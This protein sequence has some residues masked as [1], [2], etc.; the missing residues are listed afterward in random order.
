[1]S[2]DNENEYVDERW[3]RDDNKVRCD[4]LNR[5]SRVTELQHEKYNL[6]VKDSSRNSRELRRKQGAFTIVRHSSTMS[7]GSVKRTG[8]NAEVD[9]YL[10]LWQ[11][12]VWLSVTPLSISKSL[13]NIVYIIV[14]ESQ[15]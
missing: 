9:K 2:V 8:D 6:L 12:E 15:F 1:M 14:N 11:K 4:N 3:S 13:K 10:R 5:E 7:T